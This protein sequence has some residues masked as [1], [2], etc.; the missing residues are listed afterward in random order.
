MVKRIYIQ[1]AGA[2]ITILI[3]FLFCNRTT[4]KNPLKDD[5]FSNIKKIEII[6]QWEG[7]SVTKQEDINVLFKILKFQVVHFKER[8]LKYF[9]F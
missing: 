3:I 8:K 6:N 4:N 2:K 1:V 7:Y 9:R 5:D